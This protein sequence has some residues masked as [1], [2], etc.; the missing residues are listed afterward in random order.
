M[1]RGLVGLL[2]VGAVGAIAGATGI[3]AV[4][5]D[6]ATTGNAGGAARDQIT[7]LERGREVD[8]QI[9]EYDIAPAV[10][11]CGNF[12]ENRQSGIFSSSPVSPPGAFGYLAGVSGLCIKNVGEQAI[13]PNVLRGE[14][15]AIDELEGGCTGDEGVVDPD[16]ATC[17]TRGELASSSFWRLHPV[18]CG[19]D[20]L[21]PFLDVN[22]SFVE[23]SGR[24]LVTDLIEPGD[25][26]CMVAVLRYAPP[27]T[28][29]LVIEQSD[30]LRWRF[31]FTATV[32]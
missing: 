27:D 11:V 13:P 22:S 6:S 24:A 7:T 19:T 3:L 2:A 18:A 15:F 26:V 1:R 4:F 8:I 9:A 30:I 32:E 21:P 12:V 16:G 29:T 23:D 28:S 17:G 25:V 10:A 14:V 31:R 5:E 20:G